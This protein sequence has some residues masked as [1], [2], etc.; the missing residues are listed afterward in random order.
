MAVSDLIT[1]LLKA[2]L[3]PVFTPGE[4]AGLAS[5]GWGTHAKLAVLSL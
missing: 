5:R 3:G 1:E 4:A 2:D